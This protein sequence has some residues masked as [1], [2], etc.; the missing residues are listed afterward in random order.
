MEL[1]KKKVFQKEYKHNIEIWKKNTTKNELN[2]KAFVIIQK[3][4]DEKEFKAKIT[5]MKS[6]EEELKELKKT[7]ETWEVT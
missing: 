5:L 3:L 6:Q 7:V 1:D 4:Q 2:I